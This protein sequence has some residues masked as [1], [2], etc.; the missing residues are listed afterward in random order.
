M[1]SDHDSELGV[2]FPGHVLPEGR[3][4]KTAYRGDE[5]PF[6]WDRVFGRRAPRVVDLGCG[7]G[8]Y[9]IGSAAARPDRDHLGI[10]VVDRL[11]AQASRRADQRGLANI[12]FAAGDA[13]A[14]LFERLAVDSVDEI[15]L[16]HPQPYFNPAEKGK[17]IL[18]P[19]FLERVWRVVR[20]GGLLVAQTD[21]PS[22]WRY[23]R[24][25]ISKYFDAEEV[26]GA[27]P[28]APE[29]RTRR[30]IVARKKGMTIRRMTARRRE[31]PLAVEIPFVE[32]NTRRPKR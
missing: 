13:V 17:R 11:V 3:W 6:D 9:L 26:R 25:A 32:F 28:D 23:L 20:S 24:R 16:Y 22:Y 2:P 14:W 4:T 18:T 12:R 8:R 19:E 31:A 1:T 5:N 21:H 15:H 7:T 10:D 27:W 29:G 30:E